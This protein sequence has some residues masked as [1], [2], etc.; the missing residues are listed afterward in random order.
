MHYPDLFHTDLYQLTMSKSYFD[1][2]Q[3]ELTGTFELFFRT[4]PFK[5]GYAVFCGRNAIKNFID[6]VDNSIKDF[7]KTVKKF[8]IA[9][10]ARDYFKNKANFSNAFIDY[11][12]N[13]LP[14]DIKTLEIKTVEEGEIIFPH[15]PLVQVTGKMIPM[16][17][18]ETPLLHIVNSQSIIATK[19]ARVKNIARDRLVADF[20]LRRAHNPDL[21]YAAM[22][23][24]CDATSNV[25]A[26]AEMDIPITGTIAHSFIMSYGTSEQAEINAFRDYAKSFPDNYTFLVDTFDIKTGIKNA[27]KVAEENNGMGFKGIRIDS[28]DICYWA[29]NAREMLNEA[30]FDN[31]KIFA[32]NDLDEYVIES[33]DSQAVKDYG[34]KRV[35]VDGFGVGTRMMTAYDDPA[36]GAVYKLVEIENPDVT[37]VIKVSGNKEKIT[38]PFKKNLYRFVNLHGDYIMDYLTMGND[39]NQNGIITVCHKDHEELCTGL[40]FSKG[41]IIS[42]LKPLEYTPFEKID[43]QANLKKLPKWHRRLKNPHY[44]KVGLSKKL[45]NL[46]QKMI[47]SAG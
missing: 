24:G 27:I 9:K 30:G 18:I 10:N 35:P 47:K 23:G 46:R 11:L 5:G 20:G 21:T 17:I 39:E 22:V 43:V 37:P 7:E 32:S 19:A 3:M 45:F 29:I 34:Y 2:G 12:L 28:G 16:Q 42:L 25:K 15:T 44:Y 26:G 4:L 1:S 14:H 38:I 36:L 31:V 6:N 33:L 8:G 13:Q 41:Q 40:D